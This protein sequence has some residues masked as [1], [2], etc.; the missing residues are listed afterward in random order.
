V[1]VRQLQRGF[2]QS[3]HASR[4]GLRTDI[5]QLHTDKVCDEDHEIRPRTLL[6]DDEASLPFLPTAVVLL[7]EHTTAIRQYT[8]PIVCDEAETA[9]NTNVGGLPQGATASTAS[10]NEYVSCERED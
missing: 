7:A 8:P 4:R 5:P 9:Y 6:Y 2:T 10:A 1:G 3:Q